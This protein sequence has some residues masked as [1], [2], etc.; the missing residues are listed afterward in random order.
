MTLEMM[1]AAVEALGADA[2]MRYDEEDQILAVTLQDF[3]GFD[4]DWCEI[5]RDYDHP[6]AVEAFE[7]MLEADCE[8]SEGD[9]YCYYHFDGFTVQLGYASFDI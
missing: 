8:S 9:F 3:D 4:D 7:D 1:M 6:E 2:S 5:M